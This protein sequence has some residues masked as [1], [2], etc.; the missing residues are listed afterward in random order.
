MIIL[1]EIT[2]E[3]HGVQ[4]EHQGAAAREERY[5]GLDQNAEGETRVVEHVWL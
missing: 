2:E 1:G 4:K 5:H 3:R